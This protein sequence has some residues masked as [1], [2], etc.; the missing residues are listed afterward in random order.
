METK[1]ILKPKDLVR[2]DVFYETDTDIEASLVKQAQISFSAG[3]KAGKMEVVRWVN[4]N[5][6]MS[7][8]HTLAWKA[9]L[10][11]KGLVEVKNG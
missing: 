4:E 8:E 3:A 6:A 9:F 2:L 11:R 1:D 10:W 5:L 7:Y